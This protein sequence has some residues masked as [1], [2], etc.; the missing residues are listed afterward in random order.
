MGIEP[1]DTIS[2]RVGTQHRRFGM[3][4]SVIKQGDKII[5]YRAFDRNGMPKVLLAY[6]VTKEVS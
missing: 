2:W 6:Q 1:G 5:G 4:I 3:A